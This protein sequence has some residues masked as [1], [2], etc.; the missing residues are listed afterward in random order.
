MSYNRD[1]FVSKNAS[2]R[3]PKEQR[4]WERDRKNPQVQQKRGKGNGLTVTQLLNAQPRYIFNSAEDVVIRTMDRGTTKLG[5]PGLRATCD[6]KTS[7]HP[8]PHRMSVVGSEKGVPIHKAKA[9]IVRCSCE[10]FMY[11]CEYALTQWGAARIKFSNGEPAL[12]TNPQNHPIVCKHLCKFL[13]TIK[14]HKL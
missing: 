8:S 12:V 1:W 6:V 7:K 4:E 5:F 11:T 14:Q 2:K 10:F 13:E 9:V 3:T